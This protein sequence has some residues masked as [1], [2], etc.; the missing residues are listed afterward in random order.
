MSEAGVASLL[1]G[2]KPEGPNPHASVPE[3]NN[4]CSDGASRQ[5]LGSVKSV[6]CFRSTLE[7]VSCNYHPS[8]FLSDKQ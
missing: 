7:A 3:A 2:D 6:V 8:S 5:C 1:I 4:E